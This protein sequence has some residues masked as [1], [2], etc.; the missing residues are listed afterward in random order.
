[1][2]LAE[3]ER[4]AQRGETALEVGQGLRGEVVAEVGREQG[5]V[6][7]ALL[8]AMEEVDGLF[9]GVGGRVAGHHRSGQMRNDRC[10]AHGVLIGEHGYSHAVVDEDLIVRDKTGDLAGVLDGAMTF[11]VADI[12]AQAVLRSLAVLQLDLG[13]HLL[14]AFG[15]EDGL[16]DQALVP[17]RQ[18]AR[19]HGQLAG[20]EHPTAALLRGQAQR[21]EGVAI[22][23]GGIGPGQRVLV[24]VP[25]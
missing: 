1:M 6:D 18:V 11:A 2:G 15:L 21:A 23:G 7:A 19:G 20:G 17:Q 13:E 24:G 12:H 14:V 3:G 22:V 16:R 4:L 10:R 25:H 5:A 9:F 8:Q